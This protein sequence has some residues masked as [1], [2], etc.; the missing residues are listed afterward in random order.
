MD[1]LRAGS[2][3]AREWLGFPGLVEGGLA[4]L[5]GLRHRPAVRPDRAAHTTVDRA[6]WPRRVLTELI[7]RS[8]SVADVGHD[9]MTVHGACAHSAGGG[10]PP[11]VPGRRGEGRAGRARSGPR[12]A[13]DPSGRVRHLGAH[14]G[15]DGRPDQ[16][17][18]GGERVVPAADPGVVPAPRGPA[19]GGLRARA[20]GGHHRRRQ[21]ARRAG[22]DPADQRDGHRR[23]HGQVGAVLPGPAA[24]AQPVVQRAAL[25]DAH[26]AVPAQRRVPLAGG[27][28]RARH[29]GGGPRLRPQDPARGV[30]GLHGRRCWRC[31]SGSG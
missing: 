29:R 27:S 24:A 21:A 18:R 8:A 20:R 2:W 23:V 28:H 3:G 7:V 5:R 15:R 30:P 14:G 16:G 25:G 11:L 4:D 17:G 19:R 31:R 6:A 26:P 10:L 12:F 1:V 13:G 9:R 22:G